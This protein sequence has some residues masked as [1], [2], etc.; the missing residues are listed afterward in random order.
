MK[1]KNM[2]N[3]KDLD[4]QPKLLMLLRPGG[5]DRRSRRCMY[6]AQFTS[7]I[8]VQVPQQSALPQG[9]FRHVL[10]FPKGLHFVNV[11]QYHSCFNPTSF[12]ANFACQLTNDLRSGTA[13]FDVALE[14]WQVISK[15][16]FCRRGNSAASPS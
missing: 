15:D 8:S 1:K 7:V 16:V 6:G 12:F 9:I 10:Q 4:K 14:V 5:S 13:C 2:K 3:P 11:T